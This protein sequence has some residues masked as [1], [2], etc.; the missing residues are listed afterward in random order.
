MDILDIVN[1]YIEKKQ[2]VS[3][4][5]L[6]SKLKN[7]VSEEELLNEYSMTKEELANKLIEA[8]YS[9]GTFESKSSKEPKFLTIDALYNIVSKMYNEQVSLSYIA[10]RY[11]LSE[12]ELVKEL[13]ANRF[14]SRWTIVGRVL[15]TYVS[16]KAM[17]YLHQLNIERKSVEEVAK[18]EGESVFHIEEE[19]KK[20]NFRRIWVLEGVTTAKYAI[21]TIKDNKV[22]LDLKTGEPNVLYIN[23]RSLF[24]LKQVVNTLGINGKLIYEKYNEEFIKNVHVIKLDEYLGSEN[25]IIKACPHLNYLLRDTLFTERGLH[26]FATLTKTTSL[27]HTKISELENLLLL[28]KQKL[29]KE[30]AIEQKEVK[31]K[32]V[33]NSNEMNE[34]DNTKNSKS[35][36]SSNSEKAL[37]ADSI[38]QKLNSGENLKAIAK[39]YSVQVSLINKII[40]DAG[41]HYSIFFKVWT[42][43]PDITLIEEAVKELN[44]GITLY[45]FSNKYVKKAKERL[46]FADQL[47]RKIEKLGYD[48]D[49]KTKKWVWKSKARSTNKLENLIEVE[50]KT[51]SR[52]VDDLKPESINSKDNRNLGKKVGPSI[53]SKEIIEKLHNG[54]TLK[55]IEEETGVAAN[56][57]R[58][59]LK[60][61]GYKYDSFF[62]TYIN[63][64][65]AIFLKS[66][67]EDILELRAT[68]DQIASRYSLTKAELEEQLLAFGYDIY[69]KEQEI[70]IVTESNIVQKEETV[71]ESKTENDEGTKSELAKFPTEHVK[72][73]NSFKT[74]DKSEPILE[75]GL[76][77]EDVNLLRELL[78][79]KKK[80][81]DETRIGKQAVKIYL[82]DKVFEE[83]EEYTE[84]ND[85]T[86]SSLISKAL[87]EYFKKLDEEKKVQF[88]SLSE[89]LNYS[90]SAILQTDGK[91][92]TE[93]I[94]PNSTKTVLTSDWDEYKAEL[95]FNAIIEGT[96][97]G[98]MLSSIVEEVGNKI[99][100]SASKCQSYWYSHGPKQYKDEFKQ[101][102]LE[103]EQNWT[104]EDV[105]MLEYIINVEFGHLPTYESIPIASE[106]LER[107]IEAVR[108]KWF[109]IMRNSRK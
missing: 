78:Q 66:L 92:E 62:K 21:P 90:D 26:L 20:A 42:N 85:I 3:T 50:P 38:I 7:G 94:P 41:F 36:I 87:E 98:R 16:N 28:E 53:T 101:I 55:T 40:R 106:R 1:K 63:K 23:G 103:Q 97:K 6:I 8:G 76:T 17:Y 77:T 64:N 89:T 60:T 5:T 47:R 57:L 35:I 72:D 56:Q 51:L 83:M 10:E 15:P 45:D 105:K 74:I 96:R 44:S 71:F 73:T 82:S 81:K 18:S 109:E 91:K 48:F 30:K 102:K 70:E 24:T 12:Q 99:G 67:A 32:G 52:K 104:S 39:K 79:D 88:K 59:Q 54:S 31:N 27:Y 9:I 34:E 93:I 108:K 75:A 11:K 29:E 49:Q 86:K 69:E 2:E 25:E 13:E 84:K 46:R 95:L 22:I 37:D 58:I 33:S 43:K 19:L 4:E 100:F 61:D 65:R 80:E 68:V 107:H 14:K